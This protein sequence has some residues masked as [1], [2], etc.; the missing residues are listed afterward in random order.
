MGFFPQIEALLSLK[1]AW[2]PQIFFLDTKSTYKVLLS[3]HRVKPR[4][5]IPVLVGTT[6]RKPEYLEMLRM[7]ICAETK[8]GTILKW[9]KYLPASPPELQF[10][11]TSRHQQMYGR[12]HYHSHLSEKSSRSKL[13]NKI[14]S[15]V[16]HV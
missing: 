12:S 2:L 13:A 11:T 7:F 15:T 5:N 6:Y 8:A 3:P 16:K 9:Q 4:K 1:N 10:S 14:N